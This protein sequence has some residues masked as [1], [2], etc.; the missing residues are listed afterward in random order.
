M[1]AAL[2]A[3]SSGSAAQQTPPAPSPAINKDTLAAALKVM[4]LEFREA[5]LEMM[6]ANVNRAL[7]NFDRHS[8]ARGFR[9]RS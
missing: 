2:A 3:A 7:G 4:G 1:L 5:Q 6:L 8:D 9:R